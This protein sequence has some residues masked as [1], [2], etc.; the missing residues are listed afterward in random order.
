MHLKLEG[1]SHRFWLLKDHDRI[2]ER[3]I[4]IASFHRSECLQE[5][6]EVATLSESKSPQS[7]RLNQ[8]QRDIPKAMEVVISSAPK[9]MPEL[10][11]ISRDLPCPCYILTYV[12]RFRERLE[13]DPFGE[14]HITRLCT[15]GR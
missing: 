3:S 12:E 15:Q 5:G 4:R 7:G 10:R 13:A 9:A 8:R 6:N 14:F 2:S 1:L 11:G